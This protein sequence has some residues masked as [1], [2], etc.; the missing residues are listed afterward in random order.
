MTDKIIKHTPHK[1]LNKETATFINVAVSLYVG[2]YREMQEIYDVHI[3][4]MPV[5]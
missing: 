4:V 2:K 5:L 3:A 1:I